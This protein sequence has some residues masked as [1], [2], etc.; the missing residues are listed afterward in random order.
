MDI[1]SLQQRNL[2]VPWSISEEFRIR[3]YVPGKEMDCF[4]V[5]VDLKT[6]GFILS[7]L[8]DSQYELEHCRTLK[9]LCSD[10]WNSLFA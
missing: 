10:A 3:Y 5:S 8:N 9:G 6:V 2:R 7:V 4:C 1:V